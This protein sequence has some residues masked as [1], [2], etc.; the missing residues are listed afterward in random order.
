M[1]HMKKYEEPAIEVIEIKLVDVL[2]TSG[3]IIDENTGITIP[4]GF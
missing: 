1:V 3:D 2:T 4:G